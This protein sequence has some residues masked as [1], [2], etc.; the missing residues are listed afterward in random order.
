MQKKQGPVIGKKGAVAH[1]YRSESQSTDF[2]WADGGQHHNSSARDE[3][4]YG[5]E[6]PRAH[7]D[8]EVHERIDLPSTVLQVDQREIGVQT[9]ANDDEQ[10]QSLEEN[11]RRI[12][13][14]SMAHGSPAVSHVYRSHAFCR[15]NPRTR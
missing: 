1:G 7:F 13:L 15:C 9:R 6:E 8:S 4:F 12:R 10:G 5:D 11:P 2:F 3:G 14:R